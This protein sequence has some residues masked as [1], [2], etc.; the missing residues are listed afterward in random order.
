MRMEK[1]S[2]H[3]SKGRDVI[4]VIQKEKYEIEYKYSEVNT[5]ENRIYLLYKAKI[6]G[7]IL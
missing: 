3:L 1:W 7:G 6:L 4:F 2:K 5:N